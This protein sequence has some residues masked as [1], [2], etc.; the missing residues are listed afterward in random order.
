MLF[1]WFSVWN[2]TE[3]SIQHR[4]SVVHEKIVSLT[5]NIFRDIGFQNFLI[6]EY[7]S[8]HED[9]PKRHFVLEILI[10]QLWHIIKG[11]GFE[12]RYIGQYA[13]FPYQ[14]KINVMTEDEINK[15]C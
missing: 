3:R 2:H 5:S 10:P 15:R 11:S 14:L 4:S 13:V 6:S 8:R 9:L 1:P 12:I 7:I